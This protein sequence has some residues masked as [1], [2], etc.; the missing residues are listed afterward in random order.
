VTT[1]SLARVSALMAKEAAELRRSS[2]VLIGPL[3]MLLTA[4]LMP[5]VIVVALPAWWGEPLDTAGDVVRLARAIMGP[6]AAGLTEAALVQVLLFHQFLPLVALIPVVGATTLITTAV[7]GEKQARTLEPLLATPLTSAELL[8]AKTAAAFAVALALLAAGYALL[9]A[10]VAALALPG[11]AATLVSARALALVGGVAPAASLVALALGAIVST[12]AR[13]AR[14]AQQAGVVVV[15]PLVAGFIAQ[16][17]G[18]LT[19]TAGMLGL[20]VLGLLA[21][22]AVLAVVAVR[23]FDRERILTRWT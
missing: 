1:L 3:A 20:A 9:L 10:L 6:D 5:I 7:V 19:L 16:L 11:V 8:L 21:L 13:D 4:V 22:A 17:N 15:L 2:G 23:A 14:S 12:R 18:A